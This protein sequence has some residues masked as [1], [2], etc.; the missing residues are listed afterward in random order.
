MARQRWGQSA[1][2]TLADRA[3]QSNPPMIAAS[4]PSASISATTSPATAAC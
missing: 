1:A 4:M 3:P 2:T